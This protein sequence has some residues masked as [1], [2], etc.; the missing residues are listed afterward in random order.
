MDRAC[1]QVNP[2]IRGIGYSPDPLYLHVSSDLFGLLP[3]IAMWYVSANT[4]G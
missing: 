4:Y 2:A 1:R 3:Y